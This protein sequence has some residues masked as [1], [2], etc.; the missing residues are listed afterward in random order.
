MCIAGSGVFVER[1]PGMP[2]LFSIRTTLATLG[3][4]ALIFFL[5]LYDDFRTL[6]PYA[7]F[8]GQVLAA[9]LLYLDGMGIHRSTLLFGGGNLSAALG[10]PLTILWVLLITNAFNLID[11]LDGLAAGA[12]LFSTIVLL[13]LSLLR[14]NSFVAFLALVLAGAIVGFLRF[15]FHPATIFLGDSGSLF[16]GFVLSALALE[17]SQKASTMV[18]VAI[19]V[20]C[21]GLPILDVAMAIVRRFLSG[22]PLFVGD[23]EHIHHRLLKRGFSQRHAVLV[24]YGVSALFGLLSLALLHGGDTTALVL[25]IL[26]AGVCVGVPQLRYQEFKEVRRLLERTASQK[27]IIA[28]N[29][30]VRRAAE[31][32]RTCADA[33][34]LC[35]ILVAALQPSGFDG[36]TLD[37]PSQ[38]ELHQPLPMRARLGPNGKW[39]CSWT[40]LGSVEAG[41][42]LKLELR[43]QDG[44]KCGSF[45]VFKRMTAKP[46]MMDIN[47]LSD[48]FQAA[49]AGAVRRAIIEPGARRHDDVRQHRKPRRATAASA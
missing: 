16:I 15:N 23:S 31:S 32:L 28:N 18:A 5:G 45:S 46:L 7:K 24:L 2:E 9:C 1:L 27:Q 40:T 39:E 41:W 35:R 13:V 8:G 14:G 12:A 26:G 42:E 21:F 38:A 44:E 37:V 19:P 4:A 49:L 11:G 17:G 30:H 25:V 10:L 43:E 20:V 48:G 29:L 33:S 6:G 3:P 34:E 22:K 36:F 47:L